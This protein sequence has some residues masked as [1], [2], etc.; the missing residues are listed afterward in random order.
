MKR[1]YDLEAM[2][3][4]THARERVILRALLREMR[5]QAGLRQQDL[6]QILKVKQAAVSKL[7]SGERSIEVL[8]LRTICTALGVRFPDFA[9]ILEDRLRETGEI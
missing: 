6:A 2:N 8:E 1:Y 9:Q 3:R 4:D 5:Q 7:E